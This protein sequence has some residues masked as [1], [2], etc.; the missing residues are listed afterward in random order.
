MRSQSLRRNARFHHHN[1]GD[2]LLP[3]YYR[4][5]LR[6]TFPANSAPYR[7]FVI[8]GTLLASGGWQVRNLRYW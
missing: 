1:S 5:I 2:R 4:I 3:V 8:G 6:L 7:R